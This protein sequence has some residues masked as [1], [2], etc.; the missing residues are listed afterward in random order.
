MVTAPLILPLV[1]GI[2][3]SVSLFILLVVGTRVEK[4]PTIAEQGGA[5]VE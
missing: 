3:N 2:V 1:N 5:E 4:A